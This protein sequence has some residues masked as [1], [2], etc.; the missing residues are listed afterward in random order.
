MYRLLLLGMGL[1]PLWLSAQEL[2]VSEEINL[3]SDIAYEVIGELGN[4]VLLFRNSKVEFSVQAFNNRMRESWTKDLELDKRLPVVLGIVATQEDFSLVYTYRNK[5]NTIIKVHRYDPAANLIDSTELVN[6]GYLFFTPQYEIIRSEDRTKLL[7]YYSENQNI[8]RSYAFDLPTQSKLW[9]KAITPE[10]FV[11]QRDFTQATIDNRGQASFIL[12]RDNFRSRR[13]QHYY[14]VHTYSG[15]DEVAAKNISMDKLSYDVFFEPDNRNNQLI[16]AG[17][18][19]EDNIDRAEGFFYLRYQP[20]ATDEPVVAYT[21]FDEKFLKSLLGKAF[22]PGK[23]LTETDIRDLVHRRDG[24]TL[25]IA[26]RNR[27]LQRRTGITNR[28]FIDPTALNMIDFYFEEVF[29]LSIHPT[30][31]LHWETILHKRQYSQ[32]DNGIFSS[33]FMFETAGK[34]RFLFND[35]IRN[36]NTVSEYVI[37]GL[38]EYNRNSMFNTTG[39]DLRLRFRNATQINSNT[40]IIPSERK[41]RLKL[42]RLTY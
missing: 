40:L 10:D 20:G 36:E 8:I 41:N 23:G 26:E 4:H 24:G 18:Y 32:D 5:G 12:Q 39:L 28:T 3:N 38:G 19:S 21:P 42:V 14:E 7:L 27:L 35:E 25:L 34:L 29:V 17:L 37:N 1:L 33:Y 6:L 31:D 16:A 15:A 13:K 22:R 30:G 11:Y 9:E 2:T